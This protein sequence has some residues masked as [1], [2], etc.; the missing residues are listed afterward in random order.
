MRSSWVACVVLSGCAQGGGLESGGSQF[1]VGTNP[2]TTATMSST[3]ATQ[4]EGSGGTEGQES[5]GSDPGTE[6]AAT[7]GCAADDPA[8]GAESCGN[9]QLDQGEA[10]EA[11]D[12]A[13]EDCLSQGFDGGELACSADCTLDTS[14]C[15]TVSCGDG[16]VQMN[17]DCDCA[18]AMGCTAA[19]LSNQSCTS[20]AAPSGGNFSGGTLGC[21]ASNCT[22]DTSACV[23]CGNGTIDAMEV[24]DGAN[25]GGATC[26]SQGFDQGTLTCAATCTLDTGG[27]TSFV[28]G[29]GICN[30]TEDTCAC[31]GDCPNDPNSCDSPCE[32]GGFGG[33][34]YCDD[35]CLEYGDCCANGPC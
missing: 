25:L 24:C 6:T 32:C 5:G 30:G 31:P 22:F 1:G 26:Q 27:C 13:G 17:E 29:D 28:C 23:Y 19:Q 14:A 35:L 20:Q 21:S 8:C 16:I 4:N 33:A 18:G 12:L 2:G 9:G 7:E 11:D 15:T 3:T 34:C 10:C